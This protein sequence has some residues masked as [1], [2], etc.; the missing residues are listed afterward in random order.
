MLGFLFALVTAGVSTVQAGP[1]EAP[2]EG[3][4]RPRGRMLTK[5]AGCPHDVDLPNAS[6]L[7]GPSARVHAPPSPLLS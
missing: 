6:T 5:D 3:C 4:T 2:T 7:T 1:T